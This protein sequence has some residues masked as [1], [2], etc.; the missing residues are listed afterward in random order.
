[1]GMYT[2]KYYFHTQSWGNNDKIEKRICSINRRGKI[3]NA[4]IFQMY[5]KYEKR[6]TKHVMNVRILS[7]KRFNDTTSVGLVYRI[8]GID[9][10]K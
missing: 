3:C 5:V 2:R 4:H 10:Q 1:M 7:Y 9:L 6:G 8:D